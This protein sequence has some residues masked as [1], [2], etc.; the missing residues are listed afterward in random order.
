VPEL[1]AAA[2]LC[3]ADGSLRVA[4]VNRSPDRAAALLLEVDDPGFGG[5]AE[6]HTLCAEGKDSFNDIGHPDSASIRSETIGRGRGGALG[7][8]LPPHSVSVLELR[9]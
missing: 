3:G 7:L 4:L 6:L 9:P 5:G 8:E 2:T 1:D